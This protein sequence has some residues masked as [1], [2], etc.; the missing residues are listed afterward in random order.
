MV[1]SMSKRKPRK[2]NKTTYLMMGEGEHDK[3]FLNHMKTLYYIRSLGIKITLDF[4]GGGSPHDIIKDTIKKTQNFEYSKKIILMDEDVTIKEQDRTLA[5]Q[6]GIEILLSTPICLEGMLLTILNEKPPHTASKCKS[7][8]HPMLSG[9]PAQ[10]SSYSPLFAKP[11]L[12]NS[13]HST[14]KTL[15]EIFSKTP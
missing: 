8:L 2:T 1:V 9:N 5:K 7:M 14:I 12:D 15:R 4:S 6:K 11:V 10:P 13:H 3:A